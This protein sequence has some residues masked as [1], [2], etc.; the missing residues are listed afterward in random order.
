[1]SDATKTTPKPPVDAVAHK[2]TAARELVAARQ[3]LSAARTAAAEAEIAL[4]EAEKKY[5]RADALYLESL[6]TEA[7]HG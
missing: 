1:M 2:D 4:A 3:R 6:K 5:H 7:K